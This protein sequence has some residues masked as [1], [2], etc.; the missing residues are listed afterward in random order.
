M[1]PSTTS[2]TSST[3]ATAT[4]NHGDHAMNWDVISGQWKQLKGAGA[5]ALGQA[6]G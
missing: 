4:T 6:D 1:T 3:E 5:T 2:G